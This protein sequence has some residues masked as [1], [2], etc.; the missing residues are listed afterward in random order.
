MSAETPF[1]LFG[2]GPGLESLGS[3]SLTHL[4]RRSHKETLKATA[5]G[6]PGPLFGIGLVFG[7]LLIPLAV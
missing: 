7:L 2:A 6:F 1:A 5:S 3:G 4:L